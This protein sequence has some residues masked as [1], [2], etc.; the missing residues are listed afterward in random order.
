MIARI[1]SQFELIIKDAAP[2]DLDVN[3]QLVRSAEAAEPPSL[4][5][6]LII[7]EIE[8]LITDSCKGKITEYDLWA[9]MDGLQEVK[10]SMRNLRHMIKDLLLHLGYRDLQYLHFKYRENER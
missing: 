8:K 3:P 4:Q 7:R 5:A 1:A 10:L 6:Q 9:E 2:I